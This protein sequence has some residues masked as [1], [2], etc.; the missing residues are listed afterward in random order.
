MS[1]QDPNHQPAAEAPLIV[2]APKYWRL[3]L[4][5]HVRAIVLAWRVEAVSEP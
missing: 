1:D 5:R 2:P 4:I 3:P